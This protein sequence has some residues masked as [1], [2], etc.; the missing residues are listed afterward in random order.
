MKFVLEAAKTHFAEANFKKL[1]VPQRFGPTFFTTTL[2]SND[3]HAW[4]MKI[5]IKFSPQVHFGDTRVKMIHNEY[6]LHHKTR[7]N[8]LIQ[9]I[10]GQEEN[11]A[12]HKKP[13]Y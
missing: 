4:G 1:K 8:L 2:V 12:T 6:L 9:V 13:H 11:S 10:F 5:K 7:S 3:C